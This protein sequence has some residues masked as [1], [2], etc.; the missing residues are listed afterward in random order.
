MT[1]SDAGDQIWLNSIFD[2]IKASHVNYYSDSINLNSLLVMSGNALNPVAINAVPEP[3]N[4]CVLSFA[5]VLGVLK[6]RRRV[7]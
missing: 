5:V 4:I 1:G 3:A 2:N 7:H 6:R